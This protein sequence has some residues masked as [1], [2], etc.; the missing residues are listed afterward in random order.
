MS[1][2]SAQQ[3]PSGSVLLS[4]VSPIG[5]SCNGGQEI[6]VYAAN[7]NPAGHYKCLFDSVKVQAWVAADGV[8]KCSVPA[9]LAPG[10]VKLSVLNGATESPSRNTLQFEV[11]SKSTELQAQSN[12]MDLAG[13]DDAV[14]SMATDPVFKRLRPGIP[15]QVRTI[16]SH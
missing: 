10:F 14:E 13:G 8:L 16:W 6:Q 4:R 9:L 1:M 11:R 2:P 3:R 7:L 5:C 12:F 15:G